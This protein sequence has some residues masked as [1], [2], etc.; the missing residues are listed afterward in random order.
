MISY[1]QPNNT[2]P[3]QPAY[4]P[5]SIIFTTITF[6]RV[7]QNHISLRI[8]S[9]NAQALSSRVHELEEFIKEWKP[10]VILIQKNSTQ[11]MRRGGNP[12]F[13]LLPN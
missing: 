9:W 7:R 8:T 2:K 3:N 6:N 1:K 13:Q 12:Q 11:T 4:L 5:S 10:N